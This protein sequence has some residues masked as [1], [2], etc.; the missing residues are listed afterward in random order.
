MSDE[1]NH[2]ANAMESQVNSISSMPKDT[3]TVF[4]DGITSR[5]IT[6]FPTDETNRRVCFAKTNHQVR[7]EHDDQSHDF[8]VLSLTEDN[9]CIDPTSM[10]PSFKNYDALMDDIHEIQMNQPASCP[11]TSDFVIMD[12]PQLD[13]VTSESVHSVSFHNNISQF[14]HHNFTTQVDGGADRCTTP[15]WTLVDNMRPPI[16]SLGEPLYVLDAGKTNIQLRELGISVL[17]L[18]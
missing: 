15:H 13:N 1:S 6:T 11:S 18:G 8:F 12:S 3:F 10:T 4:N 17:K 16:P 14:N 9:Y 5:D 7:Y 2:D